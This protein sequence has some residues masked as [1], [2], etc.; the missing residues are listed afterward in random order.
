MENVSTAAR[1]EIV[2]AVRARYEQSSKSEKGTILSEFTAISG[3]HRKHAIRML[4]P[5]VVV[6]V[7][8]VIEPGRI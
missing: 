6:R 8:G 4:K 1:K 7:A 3:Y 2:A 5:R